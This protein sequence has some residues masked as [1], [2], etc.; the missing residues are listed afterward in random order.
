[1]LE[2]QHLLHIKHQSIFKMRRMENRDVRWSHKYVAGLTWKI[3]F[4]AVV[5]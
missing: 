4:Y 1:M 5:S 2:E 3:L